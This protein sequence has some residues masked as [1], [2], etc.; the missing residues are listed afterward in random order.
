MM[1]MLGFF[2]FDEGPQ[3][4]NTFGKI[5]QRLTKATLSLGLAPEDEDS[6]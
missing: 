5:I 6:T 2:F 4:K 1:I 3:G